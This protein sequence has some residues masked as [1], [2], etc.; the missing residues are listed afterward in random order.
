M[1]QMLYQFQELANVLAEMEKLTHVDLKYTEVHR[2]SG[3]SMKTQ[4]MSA[5]LVDEP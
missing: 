3:Y 2:A 5:F 1:R 4:L